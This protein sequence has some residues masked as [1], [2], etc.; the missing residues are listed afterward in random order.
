MDIEAK[1]KQIAK[2]YI[3]LFTNNKYEIDIDRIKI[4][5]C[6]EYIS[7]TYKNIDLSSY[8]NDIKAV[9]LVTSSSVLINLKSKVTIRDRNN[10]V[11]MIKTE[12]Q[13]G[14]FL[15]KNDHIKMIKDVELVVD[16][17]KKKIKYEKSEEKKY[18]PNGEEINLYK[19]PI[20]IENP[21]QV[22]GKTK[23]I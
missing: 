11:Q 7:A 9:V 19:N 8:R 13:V 21:I 12:E 18:A 1:N 20:K 14:G 16:N 22:K 3:N 17:N 23:R 6:D 10:K 2:D 15:N 4:S 5:Y